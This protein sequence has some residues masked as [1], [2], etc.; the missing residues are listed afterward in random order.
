MRWI[1]F[2]FICLS[3]TCLYSIAVAQAPV[4]GAGAAGAA[5]TAAPT[6]A[7]AA[8]GAANP[9]FCEKCW[10]A[11]ED[12][13]RRLCAM[14]LG[15]MLNGM[16]KPF[17]GMSGGIIPSFCP[18]MPG[19]EELAKAGVEGASAQAKKDA[20]EAKARRQSVRYL[21]TLDCRYYPEAEGALIAALRT[22]GVECVRWEAAMVLG[23]GCCCS[24]KVIEALTHAVSCSEKDGNPA[25]R[26]E[27]VRMAACLA[28]ERCMACFTEPVEEDKK[29]PEKEKA[30]PPKEKNAK[31]GAGAANSRQPDKQTLQA[32]RLA[33]KSHYHRY[34]LQPQAPVVAA[35][36][37]ITPVAQS[38][39]ATA[40]NA[41]PMYQTNSP[42]QQTGHATAPARQ[43]REPRSLFGVM[44]ESMGYR[45]PASREVVTQANTFTPAA[46]TW[47]PTAAITSLNQPAPLPNA[48]AASQVKPT[49]LTPTTTPMSAIPPAATGTYIIFDNP[50]TPA[51][52]KR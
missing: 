41:M 51:Q 12:C 28:L 39:V 21:G 26:S 24:K 18:E 14:P 15:G 47:T 17:S 2:V 46:T 16:T 35:V 23:K 30:P 50:A 22:D 29:E 43:Q 13:K 7:G 10:Q 40:A 11:C 42:M 32:A 8:A 27:R 44:K 36:P 19:K 3:S 34:G 1:R 37:R 4:G 5:Q 52:P 25:E 48:T 33:I 49:V 9:G 20:L 6:A 31:E 45:T 38:N